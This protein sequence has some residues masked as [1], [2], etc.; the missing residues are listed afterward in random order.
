MQQ[1][2]GGLTGKEAIKM[3]HRLEQVKTSFFGKGAIRLLIPELAKM[4]VRRALIVT[5]RFLFDSKAAERVGDVLL[6]AGVSYAVYYNVKPNPGID[7]VNECIRAAQ[8]LEVDL[9]VALGGG[10]AIDTAKAASIVMANGGSVEMYEG[11]DKSV[12]R[13]IPNVAVN[14]T[15]GTGSECTAFYIVDVHGGSQLHGSGCRQ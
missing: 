15:A 9:L 11:V 7:V 10:S 2:A 3:A 13:G 4:Q 14:T 6:E 8:S 1:G 12:R 5:D